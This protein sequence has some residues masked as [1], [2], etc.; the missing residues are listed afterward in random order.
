MEKQ[1]AGGGE[2]VEIELWTYSWKTG[3]VDGIWVDEWRFLTNWLP[4]FHPTGN[5]RMAR[6]R[7]WWRFW[8]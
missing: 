3:Y 8:S 6:V 4:G 7:H 2:G 1:R 5:K